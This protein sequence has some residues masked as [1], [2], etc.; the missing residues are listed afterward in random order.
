VSIVLRLLAEVLADACL[1]IIIGYLACASQPARKFIYLAQG[2][3]NLYNA[4]D[5]CPPVTTP[6]CGS[7]PDRIDTDALVLWLHLLY[8][9]RDE[10]ISR[11]GKQGESIRDGRFVPDGFARLLSKARRQSSHFR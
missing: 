4:R 9:L 5:V 11:T 7:T 1:I 6:E 10:R 3:T 8:G 2:K